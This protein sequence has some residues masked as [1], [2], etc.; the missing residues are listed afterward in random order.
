MFAFVSMYNSSLEKKI[1]YL[2]VI[3]KLE[4]ANTLSKVEERSL[5]TARMLVK[6]TQSNER[7]ANYAIAIILSIGFL[8]SWYGAQKWHSIVQKRDDSIANLQV[9]K[10]EL[11]VAK[12]R[13]EQSASQDK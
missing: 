12:L 13:S 5:E 11:E 10:L 7:F 3:A 1:W 2:D 8:L 9:E 4:A 6:I